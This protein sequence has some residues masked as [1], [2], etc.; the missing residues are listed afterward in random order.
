[1]RHAPATPK[2]LSDAAPA[3]TMA[4][5]RVLRERELPA[6]LAFERDF[7]GTGTTLE[8]FRARFRETPSLFVGA[9]EDGHPVGEASGRHE[10]GDDVAELTAVGTRNG[11]EREGI[12]SRVLGRF[13]AN[14]SAYAGRVTVASATNVEGFYRANGYEPEAILLGVDAD[15]LPTDYEDRVPLR[16]ERTPAP[17][18]RFLYVEFAEYSPAYRDEVAERVHADHVNAIFEKPTP[19]E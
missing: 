2:W 5:I 13:E 10:P 3:T 6:A 11:R 7:V 12:G 19:A 14:A 16:G 8:A 17:G 15:D 4:T 1:M 9:F 18:R